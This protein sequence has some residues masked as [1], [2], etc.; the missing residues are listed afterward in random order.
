MLTSVEYE[1]KGDKYV[2]RG[3]FKDGSEKTKDWPEVAVKSIMRTTDKSE[4]EAIKHL[5]TSQWSSKKTTP[6]KSSSPESPLVED[7]VDSGEDIL[8]EI[9][10]GNE[11]GGEKEELEPDDDPV[12]D[13][14][15]RGVNRET[16]DKPYE[17]WSYEEIKAEVKDRNYR[18]SKRKGTDLIKWLR[19]WDKK[20]KD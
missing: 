7:P 4:I 10:N 18:G 20:N 13:I 11:G 17:D 12:G 15:D 8:D 5:A 6:P 1:K 16:E 2:V 3:K 19:Q 9:L 14:Y